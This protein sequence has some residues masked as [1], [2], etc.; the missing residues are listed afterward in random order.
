MKRCKLLQLI[1]GIIICTM[2]CSCGAAHQ[3]AQSP[4]QGETPASQGKLDGIKAEEKDAG[5]GSDM[6]ASG[7]ENDEESLESVYQELLDGIYDLILAE[8]RETDLELAAQVLNGIQDAGYFRTP[9]ETLEYVGYAQWDLNADGMPELVIGG[10]NG[11]RD[12]A[13]FGR[14]IYAV[15]TCVQGEIFCVCSGWSRNYVGWMGEN[16]F[17]QL[18]SGGASYTIVGQYALLPNAAEWSCNDLYFTDEDGIYHNQTGSYDRENSEMLDM[19]WDEFWELSDELGDKVLE[20]ELTPFSA[21][22]D[23]SGGKSH[24]AEVTV[25]W[26]EKVLPTVSDH[27]EYIAYSGDYSVQVAFTAAEPVDHFKVLALQYG[28]IDE[29]GNIRFFTTELHDHGTLTADRALVVEMVFE[30]TIPGYGISYMDAQGNTRLFSVE[31]SGYDGSLLLREIM[32][33][34]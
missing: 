26:A 13:Y 17:Y 8:D 27:D 34:E 1:V 30:G 11:E 18:G 7:P 32:Q 29:E 22:A 4:D 21:C 19:T 20:F 16:T 14:D 3:G 12:G 15:Y 31:V 25:Q 10:I 9:E 6:D 23:P 2:L 33:A 28:P 5:S 24:D